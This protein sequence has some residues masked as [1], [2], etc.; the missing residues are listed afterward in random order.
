M[1]RDEARPW[2]AFPWTWLLSA[3]VALVKSAGRG[4]AEGR[5]MDWSGSLPEMI[6]WAQNDWDCLLSH[7]AVMPTDQEGYTGFSSHARTRKQ[8]LFNSLTRSKLFRL[9][10]YFSF[11]GCL[12]I[13]FVCSEV[14]KMLLGDKGHHTTHLSD[15]E[16]NPSQTQSLL[17]GQTCW[18]MLEMETES[19]LSEF[20]IFKCFN[21]SKF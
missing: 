21:F 13:L 7:H 18:K 3:A 6:R 11:S 17:W 1:H 2:R 10:W 5:Q 8:G 19:E 12:L 9:L 20:K 16:T 14:F 15:L 4:D